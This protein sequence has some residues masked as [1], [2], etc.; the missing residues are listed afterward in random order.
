MRA[1]DLVLHWIDQLD[2]PVIASVKPVDFVGHVTAARLVFDQHAL[3]LVA[4]AG[5]GHPLD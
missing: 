2:A 1:R 3:N 5:V 4:L